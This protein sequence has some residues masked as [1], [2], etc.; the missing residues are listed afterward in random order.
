VGAERTPKRSSLAAM[1]KDN[2]FNDNSFDKRPGRDPYAVRCAALRSL[3][4]RW[5]CSCFKRSSAEP[6]RR[7]L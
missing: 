7:S 5:G 2:P 4:W 1:P 3:A 6:H